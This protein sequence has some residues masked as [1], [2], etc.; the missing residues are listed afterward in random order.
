[1]NTLTLCFVHLQIIYSNTDLHIFERPKQ[2]VSRHYHPQ[3]CWYKWK[4]LKQLFHLSAPGHVL[5]LFT[6]CGAVMHW[7]GYTRRGVMLGVTRFPFT[8]HMNPG[9]CSSWTPRASW[10]K[11]GWELH[12]LRCGAVAVSLDMI[13]IAHPGCFLDPCSCRRKRKEKNAVPVTLACLY[14]AIFRFMMC[15]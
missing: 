14:W 6:D 10:L 4:I 11:G 15:C 1:M 3:F 7:V 9:T 12:V 8:A 5:K 13:E 2:F